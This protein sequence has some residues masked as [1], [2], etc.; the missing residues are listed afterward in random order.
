MVKQN[1]RRT[2][3]RLR[4][5]LP[6]WFAEYPKETLAQGQM[7]DISSRGATFISY[8]HESCPCLGQ[9]ITTHF[10]VPNYHPDHSFDIV[11]FTRSAHVCRVNRVHASWR[12]VAVQFDEPLPFKPGEK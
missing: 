1:E 5:S 3:Q 4:Y 2:E 11:N 8:A 6:V 12:H 7:I 10:K 9:H